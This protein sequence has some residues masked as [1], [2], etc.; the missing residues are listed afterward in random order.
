M[1]YSALYV[2]TTLHHR[3]AFGLGC[4]QFSLCHIKMTGELTTGTAH[5]LYSFAELRLF[6]VRRFSNIY[7][8][9]RVN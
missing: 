8:N 9:E 6:L 2:Y 7:L 5:R 3:Q 4:M 1:V